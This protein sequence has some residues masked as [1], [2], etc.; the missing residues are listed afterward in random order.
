MSLTDLD[1][2]LGGDVDPKTGRMRSLAELLQALR[3]ADERLGAAMS[4]PTPGTAPV[5][6]P[7]GWPAAV[8]TS[9]VMRPQLHPVMANP[10]MSNAE[11]PRSPAVLRP[12]AGV[13]WVA[14]V[15]AHGGAGASTVAVATADAAAATGRRVHLIS[16]AAPQVCGLVAVPDV[17]LGIDDS[18]AWR[19]GRRGGRIV[20]DRSSGSFRE[21]ASWPEPP[22]QPELT[23]VDACNLSSVFTAAAGAAPRAVLLV[24]RATVPG[25]QQ[26][27]RTLSDLRAT[28][29]PVVLAAIGPRRTPGSVDSAMGPLL[30]ELRR[31]GDRDVTVPVDRRL[32]LTGPSAGP[33][34]RPVAAAG[35]ALLRHLDALEHQEL[36]TPSRPAPGDVLTKEPTSCS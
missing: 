21:T 20:V 23:I 4:G 5:A 10:V 29:L 22:F 32:A 35:R 15:G 16:C 11:P 24:C 25:L 13:A 18:G 14:V 27:E 12:E 36:P 30:R 2:L 31:R 8:V 33:L 34:P 6:T 26:A 7:D 1:V 19:R 17:E 9:P 3:E 28:S